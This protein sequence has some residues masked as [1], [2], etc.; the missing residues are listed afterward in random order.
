M[1]KIQAIVET[2]VYDWLQLEVKKEYDKWFDS[3]RKGKK[4]NISSFSARIL[5]NYVDKKVKSAIKEGSLE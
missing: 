5:T 4:P 3:G 2:R 1:D